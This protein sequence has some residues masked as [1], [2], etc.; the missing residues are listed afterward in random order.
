MLLVP[1]CY[2]SLGFTCMHCH[3]STDVVSAGTKRQCGNVNI[4]LR[5]LDHIISRFHELQKGSTP[6]VS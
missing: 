2:A 3:T 5:V 6:C 1:W 4:T